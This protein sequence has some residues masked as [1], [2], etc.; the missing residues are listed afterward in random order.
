M[1]IFY[2]ELFC[3][4][5]INI[6]K[7]DS[8]KFA[9]FVSV[10]LL[11]LA[12]FAKEP[13]VADS[14]SIKIELNGRY[15]EIGGINISEEFASQQVKSL[16]FIE[17]IDDKVVLEIGHFNDFWLSGDRDSLEIK[18][19]GSAEDLYISQK[20]AKN[21]YYNQD[22]SGGVGF[23]DEI[24]TLFSP[25]KKLKR[26]GNTFKILSPTQIGLPEYGEADQKRAEVLKKELSQHGTYYDVFPELSTI[27][28]YVS[29]PDNSRK[30][31]HLSF[32]Y[33]D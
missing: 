17:N 24:D 11:P 6:L 31:I 27:I 25:E 10:L 29:V 22:G 30:E 33:G 21:Y 14:S 23:V 8:L 28:L 3:Y 19:H 7:G 26:S 12:L 18:L 13:I 20:T 15:I 1:K 32:R 9:S 16:F 2:I 5:Y 4:Q